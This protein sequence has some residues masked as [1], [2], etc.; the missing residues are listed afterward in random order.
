MKEL[1]VKKKQWLWFVG[2]WLGGFLTLGIIAYAI[3]WMMGIA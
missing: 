1:S 3:K 2:L